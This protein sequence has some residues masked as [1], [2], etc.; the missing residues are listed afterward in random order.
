MDDP[1][2]DELAH[3]LA[4]PSGAAKDE[5]DQAS[6]DEQAQFIEAMGDLITSAGFARW[7]REPAEQQQAAQN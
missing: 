6:Q 3:A 5:H 4:E 7:R 1:F 2:P